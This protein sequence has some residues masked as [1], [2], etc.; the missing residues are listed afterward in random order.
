MTNK[1]LQVEQRDPKLFWKLIKE[2][3][4][5]GM[6]NTDD[7]ASIKNEDWYTYF[8]NLFA[9]KSND[10]K[11]L[12][13]RLRS[14]ENIPSFTELDYRITEIEI[15]KCI[16]KLKKNKS[17][18]P[19]KMVNELLISGEDILLAPISKI[20]NFIFRC[21]KYPR[22]WNLSFLKPIHK[23]GAMSTPDNYRGIAVGSAIGKLF[24][25]V[26]LNRINKHIETKCP[27]SNNQIAFM[28]GKRTT[29]HIFTLKVIIDKVLKNQK[30][31]LFVS[32]ID[33]KKAYDSVS[34]THLLLRLQQIGICG[35]TY[36]IIKAMYEDVR[37]CI[38]LSEG[39]L[40]PI[41]S[42]I[43][44]KQ[45]CVLSPLLFNLFIDEIKHIRQ[46]MA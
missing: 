32:F 6:T 31:K 24:N 8:K 16:K 34:R 11:E 41:A 9:P 1:L 44:L 20:F 2:M 13:E 38:K 17:A 19:D 39:Y 23:K 10:D 25:L 45:G 42:H 3:R 30:G 37:Y 12:V 36:E 22:G 18:G 28:S 33:F 5:W 27:I 4:Q 26:I 15:S 35:K 21:S 7:T 29:D 43:G 46:G 40:D 14:L